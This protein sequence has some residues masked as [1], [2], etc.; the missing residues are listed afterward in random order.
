MK[1]FFLVLTFLLALDAV[2]QPKWQAASELSSLNSSANE[3]APMYIKESGLLIFCTEKNG[4]PLLRQSDS[5]FTTTSTPSGLPSKAGKQFT[6][7]SLSSDGF[8]VCSMQR[9]SSLGMIVNIAGA[10][11]SNGVWSELRFDPVLSAESFSAQPALSPSGNTLV[12]VSDRQG[13]EGGTDLWLCTRSGTSWSPPMNLGEVLNSAADELTPFLASDDT[14][15]FSSNGFGGRG[16]FD[17]FMSVRV[18]GEWQPP[19]PL[20][21]VNT[22]FDETDFIVLP[23]RRAIFVSSRDVSSSNLDLFIALP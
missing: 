5:N 4:R 16:G 6:Y 11:R 15:Y 12:F 20:H 8:F 3:Y 13:G 23:D 22:S 1:F 18:A 19:L 9:E 14:L 21:S 10:Q 17:V 2:A 7:T